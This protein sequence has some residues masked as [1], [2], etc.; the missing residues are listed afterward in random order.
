M[1][2]HRRAKAV[3]QLRRIG[4]NSVKLRQK[5]ESLQPQIRSIIH[6]RAALD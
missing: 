5:D 4:R 3:R 2:A 1:I 6:R